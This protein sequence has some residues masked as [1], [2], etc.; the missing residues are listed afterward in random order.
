[1]FDALADLDPRSQVA[2]FSDLAAVHDAVLH[3]KH[4]EAIAVEDD[5]SCRR[6]Q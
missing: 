4:V 5:S 2:S 6:D 3:H 1:M